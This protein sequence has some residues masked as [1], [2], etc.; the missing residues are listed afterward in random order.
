MDWQL[1]GAAPN[2]IADPSGV[3]RL[4]WTPAAVPGTV[5]QVVGGNEDLDSRDW[6]YR[7]TVAGP[8][9]TLHFGGLATLAQVWLNGQLIL[10]SSNMFQ[11]HSVDVSTH[12]REDNELVICFRSL[13]A[14]LQQRRPRPRWKT[15][16]VRNQQLR[17]FRTTLLGRMPGWSPG[18]APIGPWRPIVFDRR[19]PIAISLRVQLEG[20]DGIV[21]PSGS[22]QSGGRLRV[23]D[24]SGPLNEPLRIPNVKRWW[25]HTHGEPALYACV[26]EVDSR[27]YD[28]GAIGFRTIEGS[29]SEGLRINGV[30]IFCRGGCW[31]LSLDDSTADLARTL[32]LLRDAGSNMIR[33]GGTFA[34]E[35]DAF[36]G[37]CDELGIL[38]WQDFMFANMDYPADDEKFVASVRKEAT[39]QVER[40]RRH[41]SVAVYCGGSEVEQQAAMVGAPRDL[42]RSSLF[43]EVLPEICEGEIYVPSSPS[44]GAL[45]FHTNKGVTHYYGVGAY[46]RPITDARRANVRFASEC[47]A[48]ANVPER[49]LVDAVMEKDAPATHDPRWKRGVPRDN[50]S[51]WDFEDVRDHYLRELFDVDPAQLR[52]FD[53]QRYLDLSRVVT[54]EVMSQVFSEWRSARSSCR[55]GLV[56]F[57]RDLIPG[58]G[59]GVLDSRAFPKAAFHYLKRVWQPQTVVITD[60]GLNGLHLHVV[61]DR[62]T[63]L[64]ATLDLTLMRDGH[65]VV[66]QAATP[67]HVAPH[68]VTAFES[69]ALLNGF[70][71]PAY[72]YRFG[73]PT[74]DVSIATLT[75]SDGSVVA[76]AFHF[77]VQ[78]EPK[79]AIAPTV[80]AEARQRDGAWNVTLQ[81]DRF[82]YA[83]HFD[84]P[85]LQPRDNYFH[86]VPGREKTV[87]FAGTAPFA[88]YVEAL[89]LEEPVRIAVTS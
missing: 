76:E 2:E 87:A 4:S 46:L 1:A 59:W 51:P 55:G 32:R 43:D 33:V 66:A 21:I 63:P 57:L 58:A 44:G 40:L 68:S 9:N 69:D 18:P 35:S 75:A 74:N 70:Y 77:P 36:Y 17:W 11:P 49:E 6:W 65:V 12:A 26:A 83:A 86:L 42:W 72:A 64:S 79:R 48:F 73:P 28:L 8:I 29:P 85:K 23:G 25:P 27:T 60:E 45:P 22:E 53:V 20:N 38:V 39:Q 78:A 41:P 47:L 16:L 7:T 88:G 56:W 24:I 30:P 15:R 89:N 50:G 54:G 62:A 34:Y 81:S 67:C 14:A 37:L 84:T 19:A 71:D 3:D 82:L 10:E 52:S 80:V 31:T 5:A 13:N 61:N